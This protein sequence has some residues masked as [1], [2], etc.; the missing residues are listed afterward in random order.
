ME[1][2]MTKRATT[3][4]HVRYV[5]DYAI[6][7]SSRNDQSTHRYLPRSAVRQRSEQKTDRDLQGA[8]PPD[9]FPRFRRTPTGIGSIY[10]DQ[11]CGQSIPPGRAN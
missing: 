8:E 4:S 2:V 3:G 9:R 11:A 7:C 5:S 10:I 6:Y 1:Q